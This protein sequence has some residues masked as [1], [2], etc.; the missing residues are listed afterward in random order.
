MGMRQVY[1]F[2][3]AGLAL[4]AVSISVSA[5]APQ[6][7]HRTAVSS[8]TW[9]SSDT[10]VSSGMAGPVH[11]SVGTQQ[12]ANLV[13]RDSNDCAIVYHYPAPSGYAPQNAGCGI[14]T[15]SIV[16][17]TFPCTSC[18]S[19][20]PGGAPQ[21]PGTVELFARKTTNGDILWRTLA[22]F[23][24]NGLGSFTP[25]SGWQS[26][27]ALESPSFIGMGVTHAGTTTDGPVA[28]EQRFSQSGYPNVVGGTIDVFTSHLDTYQRGFCAYMPC[29]KNFKFLDYAMYSPAWRNTATWP[30][31]WNLQTNAEGGGFALNQRGA[32][33]FQ[34]VPATAQSPVAATGGTNVD[35]DDNGN[36]V[37][38]QMV[39]FDGMFPGVSD[40][41]SRNE[42]IFWYYESLLSI[43][44][45][46]GG[47]CSG[48][49]VVAPGSSP[50]MTIS[51]TIKRQARLTIAFRS[52][53]GPNGT[54][55]M[56]QDTFAGALDGN[57][58]SL[59]NTVSGGW[60]SG[61]TF[62]GSP[63]ITADPGCQTTGL[64]CGLV[65]IVTRTTSSAGSRI[66]F[67][68]WDALDP[69]GSASAPWTVVGS[70]ASTSSSL[71]GEPQVA[72]WGGGRI[73]VFYGN[74]NGA[75]I[76]RSGQVCWLC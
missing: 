28:V 16:T 61:E 62:T 53:D 18:G 32:N 12:V 42:G 56:K 41:C 76:H 72:S 17:R 20:G 75:L 36:G 25:A 13:Y 5:A 24:S 49:R 1:A 37:A 38:I 63:S 40:W 52:T 39:A 50:A 54:I 67:K 74:T 43:P 70:S 45:P 44:S 68:V 60:R 8:V 30:T 73:D 29:D 2:V 23:G 58:T 59:G 65:Y 55:Y 35:A 3:A 33:G 21:T 11:V 14:D 31:P 57:W 51:N 34:Q 19:S 26:V 9:N 69:A 4:G 64:W 6:R 46:L 7:A 66:L 10:L 71:R 22:N 48:T 47:Y 27:S 15:T